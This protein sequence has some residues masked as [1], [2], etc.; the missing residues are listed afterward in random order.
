MTAYK[1]MYKR[2]LKNNQ[3][4]LVKNDQTAQSHVLLNLTSYIY[5]V[6]R[7]LKIWFTHFFLRFSRPERYIAFWGKL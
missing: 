7:Y 4:F 2:I 1:K 5:F 6:W 3:M